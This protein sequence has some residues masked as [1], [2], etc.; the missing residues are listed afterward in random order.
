MNIEEAM[1]LLDVLEDE[2]SGAG[3]TMTA[4]KLAEVVKL[5]DGLK[6]RVND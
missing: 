2:L 5:L 1:E 4:D 6:G 3:D